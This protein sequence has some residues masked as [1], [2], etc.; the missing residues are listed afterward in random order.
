MSSLDLTPQQVDYKVMNT[1]IPKYSYL[2]I[3]LNNLTSSTVSV[4]ASVGQLLEFKIGA[5]V[6]NPAKSFVQYD[7]SLGALA[8]NYGYLHA[9]ANEIQHVQYSTSNSINI[10]DLQNYSAYG[11]IIRKIK[12]RKDFMQS[13]DANVNALG[14]YQN[15]G[16]A[17]NLI[18]V[19]A[20]PLSGLSNAATAQFA[21]LSQSNTNEYRQLLVGTTTNSAVTVTRQYMFK[22]HFQ[23]TFL[24]LDKDVYLGQDTYLRLFVSPANRF[25]FYSTE[26]NDALTSSAI[27]AITS[28]ITLNNVFLYIAV[29]SNEILKNSVMAKFQNTTISIPYTLS[30]RNSS[31]STNTGL[32]LQLNRGS[33]R[34]LKRLLTTIVQ[35]SES[36]QHAFNANS[37]GKIT[38]W[39]SYMDSK[40]LQDFPQLLSALDDYRY[41]RDLLK[42]T[43]LSNLAQY[44]HF[45]FWCDCFGEVNDVTDNQSQI[46]ESQINDGLDMN[47]SPHTYMIQAL[48][49]TNTSNNENSSSC[50]FYTFAT[51]ARDLIIQGSNTMLA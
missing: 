18:N 43:C 47:L 42:G 26:A 17:S 23:D 22:D 40:S 15:T 49:P 5:Y 50:V 31:S 7:Y 14:G 29:E 39:Q 11:N 10:V 25:G 3:N 20:T 2:R 45:W 41:N 48:T 28:S 32:S 37:T 46:E 21:S 24:A 6:F 1:H 16:T 35:P 51:F 9:H 13:L 38:Q 4:G 30:Y 27:T 44:R 36:G 34:L 8:S 19:T 12:T 33:G